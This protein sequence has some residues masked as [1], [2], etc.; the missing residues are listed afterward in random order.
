[1]WTEGVNSLGEAEA[2]ALVETCDRAGLADGQ[3][4][5]ELGCGWG[6]LSLWMAE[7]YPLSR[8]TSVSNSAPQ[9]AFIEQRAAERGLR[10]LEVITADMNDF[11]APGR[12]DRIVSVEM[13]EHMRNYDRLFERVASWLAPGGS[14]FAHI[15][16]HRDRAYPFETD[17]TDNWM[18]RYFFT[19]GIMPS[20][21]LLGRFPEH[22]R[23]SRQWRWDG[24]HY[25]KTAEAW[26]GNL[27]ANRE[28]VMPVLRAAYGPEANR[29]FHRWR[30]FFMS[31]AELF[32]YCDGTEWFVTHIRFEAS[33][34]NTSGADRST[35]MAR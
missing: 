21:D 25:Q 33:Q 31:C 12:Y 6:S 19:G 1:V 18:G 29:W 13:F 26:L 30:V 8:I 3:S 10:N 20:A 16:C 28:A 27:D 34:A 17:G 23:V 5:L 14:L 32:G 11:D 24:T 4:I 9:R 7:R 22:L 15:F 35:A 2:Q